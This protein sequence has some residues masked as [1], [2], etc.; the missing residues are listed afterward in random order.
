MKVS[1]THR[2]K[3][4]LVEHEG[5]EFSAIESDSINPPHCSLE[6]I[7]LKTNNF[8]DPD[9]ELFSTIHKAIREHEENSKY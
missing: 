9:C 6:I 7:F 2:Q 8:L 1:L 5:R 3:T 4:W